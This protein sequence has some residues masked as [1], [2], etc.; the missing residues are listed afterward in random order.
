MRIDIVRGAHGARATH[1]PIGTI[2]AITRGG[3]IAGRRHERSFFCLCV[4]DATSATVTMWKGFF[5]MGILAIQLVEWSPG[6]FDWLVMHVAT[7]S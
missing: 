7:F 4:E 6:H 5:R 1:L 2:C 3:P